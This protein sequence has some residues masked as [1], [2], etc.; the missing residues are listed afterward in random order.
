METRPHYEKLAS[1]AK[2]NKNIKTIVD[3]LD[4]HGIANEE[5]CTKLL[6]LDPKNYASFRE[7]ID[8]AEDSLNLDDVNSDLT[9]KP[10]QKYLNLIFSKF[11]PEDK[12]ISELLE[13]TKD[14]LSELNR[15]KASEKDEVSNQELREIKL[16]CENL[17]K[18]L[19]ENKPQKIDE[20]RACSNKVAEQKDLF[21][22]KHANQ[23]TSDLGR[24]IFAFFEAA[25]AI[26]ARLVRFSDY[27]E[28]KSQ[29]GEQIELVKPKESDKLKFK[30]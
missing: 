2:E 11:H 18:T 27:K 26:L 5:N 20:L 3:F 4:K 15:V 30:K 9:S 6:T 16:L 25:A 10:A 23:N 22:K 8:K 7:N 1:L 19:R 13:T 17:I 14:C 12:A 29:K 24:K 28:I 21:L